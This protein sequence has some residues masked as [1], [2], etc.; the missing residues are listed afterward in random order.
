MTTLASNRLL[1]AALILTVAA[2][3]ST[4]RG[5]QAQDIDDA[6]MD[7]GGGVSWETVSHCEPAPADSEC[8]DPTAMTP[9][10]AS[11]FDAA[12]AEA[13]GLDAECEE[14][15]FI[16][17]PVPAGPECC[18]SVE[19]RNWCGGGDGYDD[20]GPAGCGK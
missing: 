19:I 14:I 20:G 16:G 13:Q 18:Y 5:A 15:S 8:P 6:A 4:L 17:A 1:R 11:A 3:A 7:T 10:D 12:V 9:E 2:G